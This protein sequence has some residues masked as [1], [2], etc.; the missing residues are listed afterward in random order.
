MIGFFYKLRRAYGLL[1]VYWH[2]ID[3][4]WSSLAEVMLY[5]MGRIRDH[6]LEHNIIENAERYAKQIDDAMVAL[7]HLRD[8]DEFDFATKD[9]PEG[10]GNEW[11][12]RVGEWAST[13]EQQ[14]GEGMKL[15]RHWWD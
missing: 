8:G 9:F 1:K 2:T 7:K 10:R 15:I 6:L 3:G 5:Q 12:H 4:D 13:W 11:A 14:F